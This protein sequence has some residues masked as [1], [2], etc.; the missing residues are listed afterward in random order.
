MFSFDTNTFIV[1]NTVY[2]TGFSINSSGDSSIQEM[3][4]Y[5]K[6]NNSSSEFNG[7]PIKTSDGYAITV[8]LNDNN[9][10]FVYGRCPEK[11][12]PFFSYIPSYIYN[13]RMGGCAVVKDLGI[14]IENI[15]VME[16]Y[17]DDTNTTILV[18]TKNNKLYAFGG[19]FTELTLLSEDCKHFD[20]SFD[21]IVIKET[22]STVIIYNSTHQSNF[23]EFLKKLTFTYT[24]SENLGSSLY[25]K[26]T[27]ESTYDD[28]VPYITANEGFV[29]LGLYFMY[30]ESTDLTYYIKGFGY[31]KLSSFYT[32]MLNGNKT[33][34]P[35]LIAEHVVSFNESNSTRCIIRFV[36]NKLYFNAYERSDSSIPAEQEIKT[37]DGIQYSDTNKINSVYFPNSYDYLG[38]NIFFNIKMLTVCHSDQS[39]NVIRSVINPITEYKSPTAGLFSRIPLTYKYFIKMF[40]SYYYYDLAQKDYIAVDESSESTIKE[41]GYDN[42]D[43]LRSIVLQD[44]PD[45]DY[46]FAKLGY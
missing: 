24:V 42:I 18:K 31:S 44:K 6:L 12:K 21:C 46:K 30:K 11:L 8:V 2:Y 9:T 25:K 37:V 15:K 39:T 3:G 10:L 13:N 5:G 26:V 33:G 20:A 14:N 28:G 17:S 41:K 40:E 43:D 35:Q 7:N 19:Q 1:D 16:E 45:T 4:K 27:I 36:D 29:I 34:T 22:E 32:M 23:S 38:V